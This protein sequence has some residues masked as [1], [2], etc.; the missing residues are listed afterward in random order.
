[1]RKECV[2]DAEEAEAAA[3][4]SEEVAIEPA[5]QLDPH[6]VA[7]AEIPVRTRHPVGR[8]RVVDVSAME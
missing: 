1:M 4:P 8:S 6:Y 2:A 7:K 5:A 3:R